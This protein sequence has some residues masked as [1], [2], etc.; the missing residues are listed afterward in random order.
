MPAGTAAPRWLI[1]ET[2]GPFVAIALILVIFGLVYWLAPARRLR[3]QISRTPRAKVSELRP[4]DRVKVSGTVRLLGEPLQSPVYQEACAY[5]QVEVSARE[6]SQA[7]EGMTWFLLRTRRDQMDFALHDET[8]EVRVAVDHSRFA[9]TTAQWRASEYDTELPPHLL[10]FL[11]EHGHPLK[12]KKGRNRVFG[13]DEG[14]IGDGEAVEVLGTVE[15][16]P[17]GELMLT[18]TPSL[19]VMVLDSEV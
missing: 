1:V 18:G 8:G 3:R 4:G 9:V 12:D 2:L 6:Y 19:P 10:R 15:A 13:F 5:W 16:G 7:Q 17:D 11:E 14:I